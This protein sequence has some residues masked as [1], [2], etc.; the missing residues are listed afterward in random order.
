M[1]FK[2]ASRAAELRGLHLHPKAWCNDMVGYGYEVYVG[3]WTGWMYADTLE[4][5]Y[6]LIMRYPRIED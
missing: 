5:I 1:T 6:R 4:G 3:G 2:R